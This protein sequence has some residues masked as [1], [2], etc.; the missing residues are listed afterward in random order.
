ML[1]LLTGTLHLVFENLLHAKGPFLAAAAVVWAAWIVRR[2]RHQPRLLSA[3]GLCDPGDAAA[4]GRAVGLTLLSA[5]G[6]VVLRPSGGPALPAHAAAVCLLYLPWALVQQVALQGIL[7]RGLERL[8]PAPRAVA[9]AAL[10]FAAAHLPDL[11][12]GVLT[13]GAALAWTVLFRLRRSIWPLAVSHAVLGTLTYV[14]VLG[15]DPWQALAA[16]LRAVGW[17]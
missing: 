13:A 2:R 7:L 5:V 11:R 6:L 9:G 8:V 16:A 1:L 15:R 3:W 17:P 14:V 12:L 10:L 4:W